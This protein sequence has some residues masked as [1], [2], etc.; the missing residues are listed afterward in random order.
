MPES[1]GGT[2]RFILTSQHIGKQGSW[3][4]PFSSPSPQHKHRTICGRQ[5]CTAL[6]P[7]LLSSVPHTRTLQAYPLGPE[8]KTN[9]QTAYQSHSAAGYTAAALSCLQVVWGTQPLLRA[10]SSCTSYHQA[11]PASFTHCPTGSQSPAPGHAHTWLVA[12]AALWGT[13]GD[14]P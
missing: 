12:T 9:V 2:G 14:L 4:A 3:R 8:L 10:V 13:S 11:P 1:K 6:V 5:G 7:N